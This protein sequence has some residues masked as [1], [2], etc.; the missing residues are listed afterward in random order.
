MKSR[1]HS[2]FHW[3]SWEK[4][5]KYHAVIYADGEDADWKTNQV[6]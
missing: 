5:K 1:V 3:I 4:D 6:L 2:P